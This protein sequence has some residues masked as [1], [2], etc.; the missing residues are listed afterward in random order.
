MPGAG[1]GE[2]ACIEATRIERPMAL[3]M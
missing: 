3:P 1:A 2:P